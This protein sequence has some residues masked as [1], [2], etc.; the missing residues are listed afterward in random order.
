[1]LTDPFLNVCASLL[2]YED[3]RKITD[4]II[5][6][7][8]V[9]LQFYKN[10]NDIPQTFLLKFNL[11][12]EIQKLRYEGKSANT[13]RD[14]ILGIG[15]TYK[16]L[17]PFIT[18][19]SQPTLSNIQAKVDEALRMISDRKKAV[20]YLKDIPKIKEFLSKFETGSFSNMG[21][22]LNSYSQVVENM[23]T[24]IN[25]ERR[26]DS[27]GK[28]KTLD[29][30]TD[31]YEA[32]FSQVLSSYSGQNS[33]STGYFDLDKYM[34][35][36][37]E[38]TRLYIFGGSSGDGKSVLLINL[39]RNAVEQPKKNPVL[40]DIYI[41]ITLENLIDESFVRLYSSIKQIDSDRVIE[42]IKSD[43]DSVSR[44][45]TQ[46]QEDNDAVVVMCYFPPTVT[47][48]SDILC[49]VDEIRNKYKGS[50]VVKAVY[51]DY[52]DLLKSGQTFDLH[53]LELGQITI[54]LKSMAVQE[55]LPVITVTQLNRSGYDHDADL[56]LTQMSESIKK[57]EN[58]D[59]IAL[60]RASV[61]PEL[62]DTAT[63]LDS[64]NNLVTVNILKNRS[65]PKNKKV[66]L[67]AKFDQY[68]LDDGQR[69][70]SA[71]AFLDPVVLDKNNQII[72]GLAV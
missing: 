19:V 32:V 41:Y 43:A 66:L 53:R 12:C 11:V 58:A 48:V 17:E 21:D 49:F 24:R 23:Y 22:F 1:M 38:P 60:L 4:S 46:W 3:N 14:N 9:I 34:R 15:N 64:A 42:D 67:K 13:I 47:S 62:L 69:I 45:M 8:G 51:L 37:F 57:V 65:G 56:S 54:D 52:I 7:I 55:Y 6:D 63:A 70:N 68:R 28:I 36:G 29:M 30:Y 44:F 33:I 35:G 18:V 50:G 26:L 31:K 72:D 16:S 27:T 59:F 25:E 2:F 71:V 39:L 40:K 5:S 10:N 61:A 20:I